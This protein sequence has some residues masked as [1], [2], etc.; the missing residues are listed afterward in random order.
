[1]I[2]VLATTRIASDSIEAFKKLT[3]DTI[4]A[5]LVEDGCV[6]YTCSEDITEPG[7]FN[8]VEVWRDLEAFNAH[9]ESQHHLEFLR[10]L[11]DPEGVQRS[12]PA[13][14][15]FLVAEELSHEQRQEMGFTSVVE[16]N[17]VPPKA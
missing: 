11:G 6:A 1:M 15:T 10:A 7:A 3:R 16:P 5:S 17:H 2:T 14:G 4:A 13:T 9:G 12:G 8:W